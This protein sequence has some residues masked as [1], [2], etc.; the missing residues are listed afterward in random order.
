M[1]RITDSSVQ[2]FETEH[3]KKIRALSPE[4]TL[5]LKS[6]GLLPL[7][8][9][10][11]IA[12]FGSGAR[13]T[14]KGGT[15]SGDVNVRKFVT[16][17]EGIENAGIIIKSKKWLDDYTELLNKARKTF[18]K[19]IKEEADRYGAPLM[20]YAMGKTMPEPDYELE[21]EYPCDTALYVLAR[22]SG[23]GTDRTE[24]EGDIKLTKTEIRDIKALNKLYKN[25]ILVLNTG[26]LVDLSEINEVENVLLLGQLGQETGNVLADLLLGKA[27]PSG[28]LTMSWTKIDDYPSTN[29][30]ADMDD[31]DYTEGIYVGYRY[32]DSANLEVGFPFGYGKSY[33]DFDIKLKDAAI[34]KDEI[35]LEFDVKNIGNF[36]GKEVVEL[37]VSK[38]KGRLDKPYQELMAY[39]KTKEIKEGEST[40]LKL[41]FKAADLASYD[42]ENASY[43]L[44]SGDY[45]LRFGNSSRNTKLG[46]IVR[47]ADEVTISKL[48]NV[49]NGLDFKDMRLDAKLE[50]KEELKNL[51]VLNLDKD[52]IKTK[53]VEY[54]KEAKELKT[55]KTDLNWEEVK[56]GKLSLDDFVASLSNEELAYLSLG[57]FDEDE[58]TASIIGSASDDVAGAA[59][60]TSAKLT[61]KGLPS[62]VMA[63]GPAGLRLNTRYKIVDGKI[64]GLDNPLAMFADFLDD[65][66]NLSKEE[67]S[68]EEM[69][70]PINY[71]YCTAIPIGTNLA[72][73]WN[74]ELC[75]ECGDIVG[76]EMEMFGVDIW[77]A[78][79]L[80]IMRSPLCGRDFE[81]YSEDPLISG[82]MAA[83]ITRGVQKHKGCITT[84]K[85]FACNNQET[86]RMRSNSRLSER[87]LREIYLKGF[88]IAVK[89]SKPKALMSSYNLINGEHSCNS[90]DLMSFVLRDE[91]G[92]DGIVM[93][94]WL[95][96]TDIM[97]NGQE[98][99]HPKASAAGCV[100]AGNDITMPAMLSDKEDIMKAIDNDNALYPLTR[101]NLQ[102]TAKRVLSLILDLRK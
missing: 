99:K 98:N 6:N 8:E 23:E 53:T 61:S 85:H 76:E 7:K 88:E 51:K 75:E 90:K 15:G 19:K 68:K 58:K 89:E 32:F 1:V 12:L 50:S 46:A 78:P 35:S 34:N 86:N 82:K 39:K 17:E 5:L 102:E 64:K 4:C 87:A 38:P 92:F 40:K 47:L 27:Y 9:L 18:V 42:M 37:Y 54:L 10:K 24:I 95:V 41:S 20:F 29:G 57:K 97:S 25:F 94:D 43:V 36:K 3:A 74:D 63:D 30:F 71:V 93:T 21:L 84:I 60:Q 100:K 79:A 83:A 73:S 69:E 49:C 55:N 52:A 2:P 26:G 81:Y 45:I 77:L 14:I 62:L 67:A 13:N 101:A 33:T 48:K 70:A 66:K 44:E 96:T 16:I 65:D 72:Q 91:W 59:G 80:N 31:T 56:K 22:N 28:K 11:E